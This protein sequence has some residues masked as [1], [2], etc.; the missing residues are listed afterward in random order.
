MDFSTTTWILII[1]IPLGVAIGAFLFWRSRPAREEGVL[2]LRCP[3]CKRRL[4][5][6]PRQIGHKG[7]CNNCKE[8]FTFPHPNPAGKPY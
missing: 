7:M 1:G 4:R 8:Q 5:Y 2:Y 3:G 6:R